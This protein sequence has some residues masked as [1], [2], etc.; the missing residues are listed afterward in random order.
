MRLIRISHP[1]FSYTNGG[2]DRALDQIG[3]KNL[4]IQLERLR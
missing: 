3:H 2:L 4:L 1:Q